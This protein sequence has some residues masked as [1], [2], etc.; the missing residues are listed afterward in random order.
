MRILGKKIKHTRKML[1]SVGRQKTEEKSKQFLV[2]NI[3]HSVE[4]KNSYNIEAEKKP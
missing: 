1:H 3:I 4:F 2:E